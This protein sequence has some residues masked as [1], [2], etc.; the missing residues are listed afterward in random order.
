MVIDTFASMPAT[1]ETDIKVKKR[2]DAEDLNP[3]EESGESNSPELDFNKEEI[4]NSR[5]ED[6]VRDAGETY[7]AKGHLRQE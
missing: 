4:A 6:T 2:S 5:A 7:G 3:I 1:Q